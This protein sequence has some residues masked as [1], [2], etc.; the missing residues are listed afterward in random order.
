MI[1]QNNF[2]TNETICN[3]C[4]GSGHTSTCTLSDGTKGVCLTKILGNKPDFKSASSADSGK[5]E[6]DINALEK[7][8]NRYRATSKAHQL[9]NAELKQHILQLTA[10]KPLSRRDSAHAATEEEEEEDGTSASEFQDDAASD[11]SELSEFDASTFANYT[12]PKA[13]G[14]RPMP[15]RR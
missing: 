3:T 15:K 2:I 14:R 13:R 8:L 6:T 7:R 12:S 4:K 9:E 5:S 10:R 11:Q 1:S